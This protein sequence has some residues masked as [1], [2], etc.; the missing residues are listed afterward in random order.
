MNPPDER[1][2]EPNLTRV[3][4]FP[5][6]LFGGGGAGEGAT[7]LADALREMLADNR[8]EDVTTRADAYTPHVRLKQ[9]TF[10]TTDDYAQWRERGRR[11]ARKVLDRG[12][13]LIWLAGNHLGVLPVYDTL[14]GDD[15]TLV[16]QFDAHLDVQHFAQHSDEPSHANFLIHAKQPLPAIVNLGHRDL[17]LPAAHVEN[18]YRA[19]CSAADLALES[20]KVEQDLVKLCESADRIF[21]DID[22]DV[23][24]PSAFPA[25]A[26]H[27]PFGLSPT[28]VLRLLRLVWSPR[29]AGVFLSE[30][31]PG[32]DRNDQSMATLV[33]LLEYVLLSR[34]EKAL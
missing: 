15:K 24:D 9:V 26:H 32:K 6:D 12:E 33:W 2:N 4:V 19:T 27:V 11:L 34:Y 21:I 1:T 23:F 16:V 31:V 5:F 13:F 30:F 7:E 18:F 17:L 22:C 10:E 3:I 29:V 28:A 25:T 14:S 8:R 20:G